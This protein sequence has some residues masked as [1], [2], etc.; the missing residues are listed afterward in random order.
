MPGVYRIIVKRNP[1]VLKYRDRKLN[2]VKENL[3]IKHLRN[4]CRLVPNLQRS[5]KR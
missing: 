3:F 1:G 2:I 5:R 4:A